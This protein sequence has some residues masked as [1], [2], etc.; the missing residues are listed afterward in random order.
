MKLHEHR[1]E[2]MNLVSSYGDG[3]ILINGQKHQR[4]CMVAP[5]FLHSDWVAGIDA[6]DHA[7]LE[8]IWPLAPRI[9]LLGVAGSAQDKARTL[10]SVCIRHEAALET[11]DLGAAC[12]TY[13]VLAQEERPVVALLFP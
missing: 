11:M 9:V 12:R 3:V 6:L 10:Q 4:P 1:Q 7:A 13:N 8:R 5:G 2:H